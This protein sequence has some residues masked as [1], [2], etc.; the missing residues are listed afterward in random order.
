MCRM[1]APLAWASRWSYSPRRMIIHRCRAIETQELLDQDSMVLSTPHSPAAG[2]L[3][4]CLYSGANAKEPGDV[5]RDQEAGIDDDH[6]QRRGLHADGKIL[7][8]VRR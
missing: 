8:D 7:D 4:L 5:I 2:H 3:D 1:S 6:R